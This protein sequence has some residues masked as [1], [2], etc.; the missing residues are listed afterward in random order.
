MSLLG[1]SAGCTCVFG[2]IVKAMGPAIILVV[3]E[4]SAPV[5]SWGSGA[6]FG[7]LVGGF[8]D[9]CKWGSLGLWLCRG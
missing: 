5:A 7:W 6:A 8:L 9:G 3:D 4:P 1:V 2:A